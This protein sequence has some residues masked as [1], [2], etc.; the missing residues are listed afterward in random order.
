MAVVD[1]L[2]TRGFK[3]VNVIIMRASLWDRVRR[4]L[5][6]TEYRA[7]VDYYS[8]KKLTPPSCY[9]KIHWNTCLAIGSRELCEFIQGRRKPVSITHYERYKYSAA[10]LQSRIVRLVPVVL[11]QGVSA[12]G[13]LDYEDAPLGIKHDLNLV[14]GTYPQGPGKPSR[15]SYPQTDTLTTLIREY[16]NLL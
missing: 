10:A 8:K 16:L 14:T 1:V 15:D 13:R 2:E 11:E 6:S 9:R 3:R 12:L 7:I 4:I 5:A